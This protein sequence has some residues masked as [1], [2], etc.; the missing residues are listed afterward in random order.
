MSNDFKVFEYLQK[1]RAEL[2]ARFNGDIEKLYAYL[3]EEGEKYVEEARAE[4]VTIM[5]EQY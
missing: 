4:G 1:T 2:R 5:E 3:M